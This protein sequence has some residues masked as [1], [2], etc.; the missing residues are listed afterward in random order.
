MRFRHNSSIDNNVEK[1]RQID[2]EVKNQE[3]DARKII[4]D[5]I[6]GQ[7]VFLLFIYRLL[8]TKFRQKL[9]KL[10]LWSLMSR[11]VDEPRWIDS[12]L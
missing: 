11:L 9:L 7:F 8:P 2:Q 5:V 4:F 12:E 1:Q 6:D 10:I 3:N